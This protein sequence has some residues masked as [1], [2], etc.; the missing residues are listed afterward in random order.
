MDHHLASYDPE[1]DWLADVHIVADEMASNIE[2]YAY[3]VDQGT[4]VVRINLDDGC[5]KVDFEDEGSEFDPTQLV[6]APVNGDYCRPV[7]NLGILLVMSLVDKIDYV[8][9]GRQNVTTVAMRIPRK[10]Y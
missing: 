8:R 4:Y 7:G 2:K 3:G 5:L 9:R 10:N 6:E 1:N